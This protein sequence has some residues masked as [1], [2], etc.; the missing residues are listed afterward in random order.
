LK[1]FGD[2]KKSIGDIKGAVE[3]ELVHAVYEIA[4]SIRD[5]QS[6]LPRS[7]KFAPI[8]VLE[9]KMSVVP[10]EEMKKA[11]RFFTLDQLNITYKE[12]ETVSQQLSLK[13]H[14]PLSGRIDEGACGFMGNW[15]SSMYIG[16]IW[17]NGLRLH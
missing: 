4:G 13:F 7:K 8:F 9:G 14:F 12:G 2:I 10:F 1:A 6:G 15:P 3:D 11:E 17:I 16:E 5:V